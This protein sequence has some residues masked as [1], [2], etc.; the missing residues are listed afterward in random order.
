MQGTI[1]ILL[2]HCVTLSE[3]YPPNQVL[4]ETQL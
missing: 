1:D 2:P 3:N 4:Y